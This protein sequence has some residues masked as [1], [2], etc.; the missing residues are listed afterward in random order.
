MVC[1]V[2]GSL[3]YESP[4]KLTEVSFGEKCNQLLHSSP[5]SQINSSSFLFSF[6]KLG[7]GW[8]VTDGEEAGGGLGLKLRQL[9]QEARV[10]SGSSGILGWKPPSEQEFGCPQSTAPGH[11]FLGSPTRRA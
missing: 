9:F 10:A 7:G 2:T 8:V 1:V 6:F 4:A 5:F 11:C 3:A